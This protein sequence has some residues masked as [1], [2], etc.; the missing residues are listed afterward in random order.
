MEAA[1]LLPY[2]QGQGWGPGVGASCAPRPHYGW[3][4]WG[5]NYPSPHSW[6]FPDLLAIP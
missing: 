2:R 1:S 4:A 3:A 5:Q 6:H